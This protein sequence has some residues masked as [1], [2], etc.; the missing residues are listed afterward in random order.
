[1]SHLISGAEISK[2]G[3]TQATRDRRLRLLA[4]AGYAS[5]VVEV[6]GFV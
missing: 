4:D 6:L 2:I 5:V 1:M 3:D